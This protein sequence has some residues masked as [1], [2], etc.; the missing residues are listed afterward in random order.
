M[1]R[2][3]LAIL[4]ISLLAVSLNGITYIIDASGSMK[5]FANTGSLQEKVEEISNLLQYDNNNHQLLLFRSEYPKTMNIFSVPTTRELSKGELFN[6]KYT[7]LGKM[8][9]QVFMNA[10]PGL[11]LIITDN[12][13]D[14]EMNKGDTSTF[15]RTLM[16]LPYITSVDIIPQ[17]LSFNGNPCRGN[18]D[19][20]NGKT[21]L[22]F[23]LISVGGDKETVNKK[24][25][26]YNSLKAEGYTIF[27]IRPIDSNHISLASSKQD[28]SPFIIYSEKGRYYLKLRSNKNNVPILKID[29]LNNIHFSIVMHSNYDYI[30]IR[31]DT[32]ITFDRFN[33][34]EEG[35]PVQMIRP[36]ISIS[37][38]RLPKSLEKGGVQKFDVII[39]LKPI[40]P[41]LL[42]RITAM[43][44]PK[45]C[46][47]SFNLAIKTSENSL[48]MIEEKRNEFFT[49]DL[50]DYRRIYTN[51]DI[52]SY[53]NPQNN[54]I[55]FYVQ[56]KNDP[57]DPTT[58]IKLMYDNF[59]FFIIL[60][61]IL[62]ALIAVVIFLYYMIKSPKFYYITIELSAL[63]DKQT[64]KLGRFSSINIE[65]CTITRKLSSVTAKI[66]DSK[67]FYFRNSKF[68]TI[69]L[70]FKITNE[71][72]EKDTNH[73]IKIY[74][75]KKEKNN[76]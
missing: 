47:L 27:H 61:V 19:Y 72:V 68:S 9:E 12:V 25:I 36:K 38:S 62:L 29:Q 18:R 41:D 1:N 21:G 20:Y 5:G 63:G 71:I 46:K 11:Y 59:S 76:E 48:Y 28:N 33:L 17:I 55:D 74:L 4:I 23:Y 13:E 67:R 8:S 2:K 16:N 57:Q 10:K 75:E 37:P 50:S 56:N 42:K 73:I 14:D 22:L 24:N 54:R 43:F 34:T 7:L 49:N 51:V 52:L 31:K 58:Q 39:S 35:I 65:S 32:A 45:R 53:F 69:N 15:Y 70:S 40:K 3:L 44:N 60:L 66:N 30:G 26:L 6:G 64:Q